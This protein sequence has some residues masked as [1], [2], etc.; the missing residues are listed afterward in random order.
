MGVSEIGSGGGEFLFAKIHC[1]GK[2]PTRSAVCTSSGSDSP[3]ALLG[4]R[5]VSARQKWAGSIGSCNRVKRLYASFKK[6][7][8]CRES[9]VIRIVDDARPVTNEFLDGEGGSRAGQVS[10]SDMQSEGDSLP[11]HT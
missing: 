10:L 6:S 1:K 2:R 4:I 7:V 9:L 3:A 5:R 11:Y 8:K